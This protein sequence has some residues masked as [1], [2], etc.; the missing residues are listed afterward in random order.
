MHFGIDFWSILGPFWDHFGAQNGP[1]IDA[2]THQKNDTAKGTTEMA[3][4]RQQVALGSLR[5]ALGSLRAA[6]G[7]PRGVSDLCW[8]GNG[9]S[10][11]SLDAVRRL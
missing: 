2:K 8:H 3:Q 9:K 1:K 7:E 5:V 4:K 11:K 6:L 10:E